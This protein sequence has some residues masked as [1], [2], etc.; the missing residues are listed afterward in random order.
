MLNKSLLIQVTCNIIDCR[1]SIY[2]MLQVVLLYLIISILFVRLSRTI[3]FPWII[4]YND[5]LSEITTEITIYNLKVA[6]FYKPFEANT[7]SYAILSHPIMKSKFLG[8]NL[9]YFKNVQIYTSILSHVK[10]FIALK[11]LKNEM[12]QTTILMKLHLLAHLGQLIIN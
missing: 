2:N 7:N 12:A 3:Y 8:H 4:F 6:I 1:A 5:A 11:S 9:K 10:C